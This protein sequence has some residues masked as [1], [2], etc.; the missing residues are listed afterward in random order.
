ME[1]E[2][3]EGKNPRIHR[4]HFGPQVVEER[5]LEENFAGSRQP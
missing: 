2:R 5:V 1:T 3:K 4:P